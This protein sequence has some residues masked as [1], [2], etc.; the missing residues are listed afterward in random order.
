MV[1][2]T[3][4]VLVDIGL[5]WSHRNDVGNSPPTVG[6]D[7]NVSPGR[8]EAPPPVARDGDG[9]QK[10]ERSHESIVP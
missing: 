1:T 9:M 3:V 2:V 7:A 8:H 6:L 10:P 4:M 5:V